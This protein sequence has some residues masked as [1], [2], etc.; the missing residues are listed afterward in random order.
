[1][2]PEDRTEPAR[3]PESLR[4]LEFWVRE[5]L[6]LRP[7]KVRALMATIDAVFSRH[8]R[9]WQESK[10][11]AIQALS[12]GFAE[13][14]NGLKTRAERQ[15]SHRQQHLALLRTAGRGSHREDPPRSQDEADELQPVHRAARVVPGARTA[16][17]LV[18]SRPG[19]HHGIQVVQ[20]RARPRRRRSHHRAGRAA[21]ARAGAVGRPDRAGAAGRGAA[22][23]CTRGSA[24][25]SS[26]S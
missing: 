9:L 3:Q 5:H 4:D 6:D 20:R 18:R 16:R 2:H 12:A 23:I 17:A 19:R 10:Q 13:K 15:G 11:D 24:A 7:E 26:V 22:R 1:M 25:T 8:E 21:A 14:M